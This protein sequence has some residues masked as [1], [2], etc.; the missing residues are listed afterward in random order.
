M[1]NESVDFGARRMSKAIVFYNLC[2]IEVIFRIFM[3]KNCLYKFTSRIKKIPS[4]AVKFSEINIFLVKIFPQGS[5]QY[6]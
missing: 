6:S 3:Y 5:S 4:S 2:T 1:N